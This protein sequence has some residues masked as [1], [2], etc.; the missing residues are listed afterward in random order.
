MI[1]TIFRVLYIFKVQ[2][3]GI[4]EEK[5]T[6]YLPKMHL[7][8]GDKNFGQGPSSPSFGQNPKEQIIFFVKP[9]L[10]DQFIFTRSYAALW[11]ADRDMIVGPGYSSIGYILEKNHEKPTWNHE[12]PT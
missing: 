8:K 1:G 9:S 12:K 5:D 11:A 7:W 3:I 4:L 2:I 6:F 10:I